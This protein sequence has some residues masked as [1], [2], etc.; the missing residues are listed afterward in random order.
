MIPR[1]SF[2]LSLSLATAPITDIQVP[3]QALRFRHLAHK[4]SRGLGWLSANAARHPLWAHKRDFA[5]PEKCNTCWLVFLFH[6]LSRL[7]PSR[8]NS[9]MIGSLRCSRRRFDRVRER[10]LRTEDKR[11]SP[12]ARFDLCSRRG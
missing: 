5:L 9:L 3:K 1:S 8:R 2:V 7:S 10:G 4:M 11:V 6:I 12:S